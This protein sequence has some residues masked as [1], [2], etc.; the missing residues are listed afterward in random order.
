M[1]QEPVLLLILLSHIWAD[2]YCRAGII[3]LKRI[4]PTQA[5]IVHYIVYIIC[6]FLALTI[7]VHSSKDFWLTWSFLCTAYIAMDLVY[8]QKTRFKYKI[9]YQAIC[10]SMQYALM[11][12]IW[13]LFG[14]RLNIVNIDIIDSIHLSNL[15]YILF[16]FL[17]ITK[18]AG[19][20]IALILERLHENDGNSVENDSTPTTI[21]SKKE[22]NLENAGRYIGYLERIIMYIFI[23]NNQFGAIAFILT[24]KSIV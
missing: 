21:I 9:T 22:I 7:T 20:L 10:Q 17:C 23:I 16:G 18:P 3:K 15:P 12:I 8:E 24:A 14:I 13:R 5:K 6:M 4:T 1:K 2:I 11:I 19:D